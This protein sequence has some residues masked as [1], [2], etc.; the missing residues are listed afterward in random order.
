ML[1]WNELESDLGSSEG[2]DMEQVFKVV[3]VKAISSHGVG[4]VVHSCSLLG[5]SEPTRK[6]LLSHFLSHYMLP[7]NR[8]SEVHLD[9]KSRFS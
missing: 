8:N 2:T 7:E 5:D 9:R 6:P 4:K 1:C 3:S